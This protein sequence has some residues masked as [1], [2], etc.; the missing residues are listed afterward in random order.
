MEE[1][2]ES[3]SNEGITESNSKSNTS[4]EVTVDNVEK[5]KEK[6]P[7]NKLKETIEWIICIIIAIILALLFRFYVGVPTVVKNVSMNPTLIEGQRLILNRWVRTTS[8]MPERGDIVTIEEPDQDKL[9]I[10]EDDANFANPIAIY[11]SPDGGI[12]GFIYNVLEIGKTSFIKRVIGLPGD[13]IEIKD[14]KVYINDTELDEPYLKENVKTEAV[15]GV[16]TNIVVPQGTVFVM[17]DNRGNSTDS[18]HFGCIPIEKIESKVLVRFWPLN[19]M[20]KV[21]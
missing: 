17:G 21:N 16:F 5:K 20:G 11:N 10:Q 19:L 1:E 8:K 15:Q 13:H 14:G 18:R 3:I 4:S 6:P 2:K 7:V 12:D 9:Y